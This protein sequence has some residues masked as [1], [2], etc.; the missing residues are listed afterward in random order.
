MGCFC[1]SDPSK[2]NDFVRSSASSKDLKQLYTMDNQ[3]LGKGSFG[4]VY[5]GI[6]RFNP[7][8]TVAIKAID[9]RRLSP[10]EIDDIHKEVQTLQSVDHAH[11]INYFETY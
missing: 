6:N 3:I 2:P 11:I 1:P 5:K 7:N 10:E 4:T 8:M 9:K